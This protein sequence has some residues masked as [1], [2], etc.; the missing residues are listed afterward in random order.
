MTTGYFYRHLYVLLISVYAIWKRCERKCA[1][2]TMSIPGGSLL[3]RDSTD[4]CF[5]HI[6]IEA[7]S[8]RPD[9]P[10]PGQPVEPA[11]APGRASDALAPATAS[12]QSASAYQVELI[13]ELP[14]IDGF[15]AFLILFLRG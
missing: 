10:A 11:P 4:G 15:P 12:Q 1:V 9:L 8:F 6:I 14:L 5:S 13:I 3:A 7:S 2:Y